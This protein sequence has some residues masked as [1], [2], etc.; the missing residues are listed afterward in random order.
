M[1]IYVQVLASIVGH[2]IL[3]VGDDKTCQLWCVIVRIKSDPFRWDW[4]RALA[5]VDLSMLCQCSITALSVLCCL[6]RALTGHTFVRFVIGVESDSTLSWA[7]SNVL[8]KYETSCV[9]VS[10]FVMT[11]E[12]DVH[13]LASIIGHWILKVGD[14]KTCQLWCVIVRIKRV[15]FR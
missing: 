3:K 6:D 9:A 5:S 11:H 15:P 1:K 10:K 7:R 2:W 12:I 8:H 14:D 13:F 4:K